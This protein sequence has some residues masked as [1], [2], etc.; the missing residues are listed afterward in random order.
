MCKGGEFESA[1]L[2]CEVKI[3]WGELWGKRG[4]MAALWVQRPCWRRF[5]WV[6]LG[7]LGEMTGCGL[8]EVTGSFAQVWH[9]GGAGWCRAAELRTFL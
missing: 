2:C 6:S 8:P 7:L 4:V 5:H 1:D 3:I 9:P